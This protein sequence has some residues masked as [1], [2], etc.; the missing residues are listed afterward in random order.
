[1]RRTTALF[2]VLLSVISTAFCQNV[3]SIT[4]LKCENKVNPL[5]IEN[6]NPRLN[7]V[8]KSAERDQIQ[9]AYR[10]LVSDNIASLKLNIGNIWDSKKVIS[11]KSILV[12]FNGRPLQAA[13]K[14]FW[15]VKV[16]N[17]QGI[18]SPWSNDATFSTGLFTDSDWSNA[19]WIGY[20]R[21]KDSMLLVPGIHMSGDK[22][23]K[24]A[25]QRPVVPMFRKEF[26]VKK[27]ISYA[28]LFISGLGHYEASINGVK[29]GNSFLAPGW[30]DY[31][32]TVL[33]N[34]YDVT[35]QL[36]P[37]KNSIGV[38]VGNG[39]HNINRERYRKLVITYGMP[40]M[41]SKLKIIYTD[42][43][44][45]VIVSGGD[46]K[47]TSS[48]ITFTSIYGGEDYDARLE[49][50]GWNIPGFNDVNWNSALLVEAP[51]G[52]LVA[53]TD[54]PLQVRNVISVKKISEP[55][56]GK[57]LY[58]FGQNASGIIEMKVQGK[59]GQVIKL[60]PGELINKNQAINQRA[61][62]GPYY[63]TYTLK[64]EGV[65]TWRPRFTYYGFRYCMVEGADPA[66]TTAIDKT[67]VTD[68]PRMVDLKF[69]H[70]TNSS[71]QSGSFYCSNQQFNQ[72][73]DLINWAIRSNTQSVVTD[74]PHREKLGWLEQTFLMGGSMFYNTNLYLLYDKVVMDMMD[75]QTAT[76]LIP[77]IAPEYVPF[78]NGF[79]DSPEWG[80]AGVILPWMIYQW[81]GDK[82]VMKMAY[83][84][85][86]KYVD[87]LGTKAKDHIVSH[88]LGDWYDLGPKFPGEAQLTPKAVTATAI[89]YYDI[90]L[91]SQMAELL[92]NNEDAK[93]LND[94]SVE[95]KK[96]FNDKFFNA[97][98][99]VYSTGSQTAMSMPLCVGLVDETKRGEVVNNLVASINKSGKALTAGDIGFHFLVKALE[100]SGQS[101][102]LYDMNYRNDIPGYGFQLK[103]GATALT[104][105]WAALEEVSNNHL[106]LGHIME[107]FYTGLGGIKQ[108][109]QSVAFKNI[110]IRPET[111]GD[112][113][114]AKTTYLSPYGM[115]KSEW[116]K[117]DGFFTLKV[118]VPVNA[119]ATVYL[120]TT[121]SN[122]V[123]ESGKAISGQKE[124]Q[125]IKIEKDKALYKIGS[126][127]Y[128]FKV[129]LK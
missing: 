38:M 56:P 101:Q 35:G 11:D 72:T 20:E 123:T 51:K 39:F 4:D 110:I 105:S 120:P 128:S 2:I 32:K 98:T 109:N 114:E 76:G 48:P 87:Y 47:C 14:Y 15:K 5:G 10:V 106:M 50:K 19:H 9:T 26:N 73:Y 16:W 91:L 126:G 69:L 55:A 78:E 117:R 52:K 58:D 23:G 31:D 84:M 103:K 88:G 112:I 86:K 119:S 66:K 57:Y 63:F 3:L 89:Y 36:K 82:E 100:E 85:M 113:S 92:E 127:L 107:W 93:Q 94:L 64:G 42:G 6:K 45:D 129:N 18:E 90:I 122:A 118:E 24:L 62:G 116:T 81:Y 111:V 65:E 28:Q 13:K 60:T 17:R 99:N 102:L 124:I 115:I 53:E 46:W 75:A 67:V 95:V 30:T 104:E 49:Q 44:E 27:K 37:G 70:T 21:L 77:D 12:D 1:V 41:I 59:K 68:L 61:S 96:A 97:E 74:C 43:T 40:R 33:Y 54:Y 29:T 108:D 8:L 83:P 34:T 79:R 25:L 22:A 80:S 125:F 71:P 121:N 7:W